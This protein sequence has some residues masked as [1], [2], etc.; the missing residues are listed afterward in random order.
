M[1][2]R[3]RY[4]NVS[5]SSEQPSGEAPGAIPAPQQ[6]APPT[7]REQSTTIGTGSYVAVSC[8]VM[9]LALTALIL[10]I[11]FLVRWLS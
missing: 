4:G 6:P 8:T 10:G 7:E 5:E 11:L 9:A 1:A 3:G 2:Q